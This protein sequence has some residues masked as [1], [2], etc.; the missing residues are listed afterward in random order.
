MLHLRLVV[1]LWYNGSAFQT[2][3]TRRSLVPCSPFAGLVPV[4]RDVDC[5]GFPFCGEDPDEQHTGVDSDRVWMSRIL[6]RKDGALMARRQDQQSVTIRSVHPNA[7][8]LDLSQD[9]IW[10]AVPN[11][12]TAPPVRK[13]GT[14]TP[15]VLALA[16]WLTAC[17]ID[18]V[19]MEATGVLWIPVY[20]VLEAKGF[21]V[22]VVNARHVK[23]VP[24]RKSDI[25]DCQWIQYLH[26]VGLLSRSFRPDAEMATLRAYLRHRAA[27]LEHRAAHI[28]HMQKAL[29]QMNVQLTQVLSDITGQTGLAIIRSIVAGERDPQHLAQFRDRR[30]ARAEADIA[31]ALT[32]NYRPEHVFALKQ[33]LALYDFYTVQVQECDA[34]VERYVDSLVPETTDDLPPLPPQEKRDSHSKNAPAY[35]ARTLFYRLAGV[36]LVAISGLNQ[37]TVQ[38]IVS[39]IG[40]DMTRW[41]SE[42]HFSSW[43]GLAPHNDISGGKVLR[44]KTLRARNAA[45]QAFRL[46]AQAVSRSPRSAFGAFYRRVKGRLGAEQALVATAH[47]IARTFYT[48]LK[49]HTPFHDIGAAEYDRQAR[50]RELTHL[51]QRAAKLGFTLTP[52]A[53]PIATA[54]SF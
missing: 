29:Q 47:K 21:Q 48:V 54:R 43:L 38:T 39:E 7:A 35:D 8:G 13:F 22:W 37:S 18:S 24:G 31:K 11:D 40:L 25:K 6:C 27:L 2:A 41:P 42:K 34:E 33:A 26:S 4:S 19:A 5:G 12:R 44:S 23:N 49:N 45:G 15:D 1:C 36:D 16:D 53:E 20:E 32:G 28:Q 30:C 9:E 14:F 10:A 51:R 3:K 50:E 52:V 46:A 17:H